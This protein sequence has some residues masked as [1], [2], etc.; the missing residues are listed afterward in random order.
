MALHMQDQPEL[1]TCSNY[2]RELNC[3]SVQRH[4]FTCLV[5][6]LVVLVCFVLSEFRVVSDSIGCMFTV[7]GVHPA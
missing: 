1:N 2:G 3:L 6:Y 5:L 4:S 7:A